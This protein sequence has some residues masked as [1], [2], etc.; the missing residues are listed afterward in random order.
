LRQRQPLAIPHWLST[1]SPKRKKPAKLS[2]TGYPVIE[3][4]DILSTGDIQSNQEPAG[5]G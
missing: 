3:K 1:P 5:F 4:I 2:L